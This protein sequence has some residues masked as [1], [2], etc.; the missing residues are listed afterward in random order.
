MDEILTLN[1]DGIT[2]DCYWEVEESDAGET[3]PVLSGVSMY[4]IKHDMSRIA[5]AVDSVWL[6]AIELIPA[7]EKAIAS[8]EGAPNAKAE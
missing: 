8:I 3:Y 2:F 5:P 7:T 6:E 4:G 1:I